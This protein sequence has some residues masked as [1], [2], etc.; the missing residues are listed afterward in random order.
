MYLHCYYTCGET[1]KS[2]ICYYGGKWRSAPHYPQPTHKTVIEPF[3]GAAGYSSR[4][5]HLDVLL[6]DKDPIIAGLWDYLIHVPSSEIASLPIVVDH[7]DSLA[8]CQEAKHLIGFW[9]NAG[10]AAPCKSPSSWMRSGTRPTAFWGEE[11]RS[12]IAKQVEMIR[13]W[14]V[15]CAD[16]TDAPDIPATWFIDPPYIGA[17]KHYRMGCA[18]IDYSALAEW[19]SNREGQVIVCEND[20]ANWL[21]FIPMGDLKSTPGRHRKGYSREVFYY[22]PHANQFP[23]ESCPS[24]AIGI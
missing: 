12:R 20:G 13:H 2:M 11:I 24:L 1:L 23:I 17:G 3:A 4:Y 6:Y 21:P 16:Y 8:C 14:R 22:N 5:P 19:C 18:G 7:T 10:S 9:L 15:K